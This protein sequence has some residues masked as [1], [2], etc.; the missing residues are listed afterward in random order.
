MRVAYF[1]IATL[2]CCRR[3]SRLGGGERSKTPERQKQCTTGHCSEVGQA[4]SPHRSKAWLTLAS[5]ARIRE[6]TNARVRS[7]FRLVRGSAFEPE[8]RRC[9]THHK[10]RLL[11][12]LQIEVDVW[13]I[14]FDLSPFLPVTPVAAFLRLRMLMLRQF[15]LWIDSSSFT[16]WHTLLIVIKGFCACCQPLPCCFYDIPRHLLSLGTALNA[17]VV[18]FDTHFIPFLFWLHSA[19]LPLSLLI[20]SHELFG[21]IT[22][23]Y[24]GMLS[25]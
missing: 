15:S 24:E 6:R 14:V 18:V 4:C 21:F 12:T 10:I 1:E 25:F 19:S 22:H 11:R 16:P 17:H 3:E 7:S 13:Y 8:M 20:P 9:Y 23:I 5:A 2:W